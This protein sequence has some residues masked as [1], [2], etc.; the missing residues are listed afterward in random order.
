MRTSS[1]ADYGSGAR[2]TDSQA[3]RSPV[4]KKTRVTGQT[5]SGFV[6]RPLPRVGGNEIL[7]KSPREEYSIGERIVFKR[8]VS[9]SSSDSDLTATFPLADFEA[10][11]LPVS[12]IEQEVLEPFDVHRERLFRYLLSFPL[13]P[14]DSEEIIQG[15][16]PRAFQTSRRGKSRHN[17]RGW[18][19]RM[20][21]NLAL[22]KR[23]Q[24]RRGWQAAGSMTTPAEELLVDPAPNLEDQLVNTQT[25]KRVHGSAVEV[26]RAYGRA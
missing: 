24:D 17:L 5:P 22:Y 15:N 10:T 21:H 19:F 4:W 3:L 16:I 11:A 7:N 25:S 9:G 12:A 2:R 18:L 26:T 14:S 23:N 1:C 6:L 8:P 13:D 20:A